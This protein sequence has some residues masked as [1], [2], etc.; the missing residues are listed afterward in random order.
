[1]FQVK[2]VRMPKKFDGTHR[3]FAFVE[4]LTRDEAKAAVEAL[5]AT[6]VYGRRMVIEYAAEDQSLEAIQ[7]KAKRDLTADAKHEG[8]RKKQKGGSEDTE[9]NEFRGY[10]GE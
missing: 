9:D 3:G 1:M 2:S 8:A 5:S 4:F 7:A 6:H 10:G